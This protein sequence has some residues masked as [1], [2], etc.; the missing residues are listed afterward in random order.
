MSRPCSPGLLFAAQ[1]STTKNVTIPWAHIHKHWAEG[2]REASG[3]RMQSH[4]VAGMRFILDIK[5]FC[6]S[7]LSTKVKVTVLPHAVEWAEFSGGRSRREPRK[8]QF[9][10]W[11]AE[12]TAEMD[13][14]HSETGVHETDRSVLAHGLRFIGWVHIVGPCCITFSFIHKQVNGIKETLK[15]ATASPLMPP[16]ESK[17][18][19]VNEQF[20]GSEFE[21][22]QLIIKW[23][24]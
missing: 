18:T 16:Q 23:V 6:I 8:I 7:C 9:D 2:N 21:K 13:R 5:T 17:F 4:Y 3:D 24:H 15:T 14:K 22:Q 12:L 11:G 19:A 20:L 1:W 10:G